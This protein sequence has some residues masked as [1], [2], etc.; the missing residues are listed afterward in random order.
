MRTF[1]PWRL[2]SSSTPIRPSRSCKPVRPT[3]SRWP[4]ALFN[5]NW[6]LDAARK[7]GV[8]DDYAAA[9]PNAAFWLAKRENVAGLS[10]STYGQG[11]EDNA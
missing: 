10:P 2:A 6:P 7:L 1:K 9:P 5:P 4:E 8:G 3:S 11:I